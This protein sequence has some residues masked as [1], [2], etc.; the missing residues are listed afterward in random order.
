MK[1]NIFMKRKNNKEKTEMNKDENQETTNPLNT[2][3]TTTS[4]NNPEV[5]TDETSADAKTEDLSVKVAELNDKFLRLYSEFDNYRKR[6]IKER[7]EL[8]KTAS[9]EVIVQLLPV[10]DDFERA[11]KLIPENAEI[12]SFTEGIK[13]IYAKFK[14]TLALKGLEEIKSL[15]MP[16]DTDFHE[17][18]TNI[19]SETEEQKGKVVDEIQKGYLL[20][21]KVIRFAK[22]VIGA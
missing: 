12:D 6:T 14:N 1:N 7:I 3:E 15:G 5:L 13:L 19:P 17:A 2:E 18:I 22:V 4:G 9:E 11:I 16:F 10:L 20:S 21:G 8:S